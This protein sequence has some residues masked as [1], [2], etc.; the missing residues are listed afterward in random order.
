M[1]RYHT[2]RILYFAAFYYVRYEDIACLQARQRRMALRAI[3]AMRG[4][5]KTNTY[6]YVP[7][8]PGGMKLCCTPCALVYCEEWPDPGLAT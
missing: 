8:L 5:L 1:E 2:G 7:M 6:V 4:K 3:T